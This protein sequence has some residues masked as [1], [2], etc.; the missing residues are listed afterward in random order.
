MK[1]DRWSPGLDRCELK[2]YTCLQWEYPLH[3]SAFLSIAFWL[4]QL[5]LFEK[6]NGKNL[7][8][9][10]CKVTWTCLEVDRLGCGSGFRFVDR[11]FLI[12][13]KIKITLF[14][15]YILMW[16]RN[17]FLSSTQ[18]AALSI[19]LDVLD[20]KVHDVAE[21]TWGFFKGNFQTRDTFEKWFL[22][23]DVTK[24]ENIQFLSLTSLTF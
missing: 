21:L 1:Q 17:I 7:C 23:E 3:E 24:S 8:Y 18:A 4:W 10:H 12:C 16:K 13:L 14:C 22:R 9:T 2:V 19:A 5:M 11:N 20:V 6:K 15:H